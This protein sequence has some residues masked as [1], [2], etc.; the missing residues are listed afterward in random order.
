METAK[1][2]AKVHRLKFI[3]RD[4]GY[5]WNDRDPAMTELCALIHD[6]ELSIYDICKEVNRVSGGAYNIAHGT[7]DNWLKGKTRRPT[8]YTLTWV[9]YALG[10]ERKWRKTR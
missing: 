7:I 5:R 3:E 9:G 4:R 2:I 6:S 10:Y 1:A 8:N